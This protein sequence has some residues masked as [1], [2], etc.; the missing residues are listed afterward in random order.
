MKKLFFAIALIAALGAGAYATPSTQIWI[1]STDVQKFKTVHLNIDNYLT[2]ANEP[3]GHRKPVV[4]VIGP[5]V[6]VLPYEKI[7]AEVGFDIIQQGNAA[8][9]NAPVYLN[10]KVATPENSW[11]DQSPALAAGIYNAGFKT[12][13]TNQN[14]LYAL[15]A[16]TLP[17]AGRVSAGYYTGNKKVL[18]DE[19]GTAQQ[20]GLLLSW[21][22][23]MPE[24]SDNLWLG[25]DYQG[26]KSALGALSFGAAWSFTPKAS[27]LFGY[28]VYNNN[29]AAGRN[30]FTVQVDINFP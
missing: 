2:S 13:Y 9:D 27:V 24:I 19:N 1:P 18:L 11:F 25:V 22:R 15:L 16:K 14:V 26:G 29:D 21:D 23:T 3:D 30:T 6:G 5:T 7:Q 10:G 17:V 8:Y 28:D 4:S 12:D 20:N